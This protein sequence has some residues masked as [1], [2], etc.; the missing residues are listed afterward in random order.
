MKIE[1]LKKEKEW[2]EFVL[3]SN[4]ATY[5]H[6]L[7]WR[8]VIK[9]SYKHQDLYLVAKENKRIKGI[10][11][12]FVIKNP[13]F[14]KKII[15]LPFLNYGGPIAENEEV[16][17][18]LVE[19][20]K[21]ILKEENCQFFQIRQVNPVSQLITDL[22]N[23]SFILTLD[24]NL[25]NIW[26]KIEAKT[27]NQIRKSYQFGPKLEKGTHYLKDFYKLYQKTM[28]RVGTPVHSLEFFRNIIEEFPQRTEI[29]IAKFQDIPV[30]GMILFSFKDI[31][32]NPWSALDIRY[33]RTNVNN[34]L[35]WEAIKYA[36]ERN[37]KY[38][39]FGRSPKNSGTFNFKKQWNGKVK[40]LYYQHY[41]FCP[42]SDREKYQYFAYI[43]S[44]LPLSI[45]NLLGPKIRKYI[46]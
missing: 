16:T 14:G 43:W 26:Q 29:L 31:L 27:R 35:Y 37:F 13:I 39:D 42:L 32:S 41:P 1:I 3:K 8:D 36:V 38:F 9:K 11:P 19:Y 2:D 17:N 45:T 28:K 22:S 33:K 23:V 12:L 24:K 5:C 4:E 6:L 10:F 20:L 40:Q 15:S 21:K 34:F 25:E 46:P 18:A 7:G 30:A 44:K